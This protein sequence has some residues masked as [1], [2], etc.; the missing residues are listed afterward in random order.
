MNF[1][2]KICQ[3][4]KRTEAAPLPEAPARLE[5]VALRDATMR[6][7]FNT[8]TSELFTN[9]PVGPGDVVADIGCGDGGNARFCAS[10]GARLILADINPDSVAKAAASVAAEP[11]CAG[12]ES[13]ATDSDPLPIA[14]NSVS[15]VVCTEVIEH[16]DE[17]ARLMAE[18][19][20]I[21]QP[22]ARYLIA[23][24]D[25]GSEAV[26]KRLAPPS[27]FEKPNHIRV[28]QHD[29]FA[30]Y[31]ENAGL[32]IE[33]RHSHGFYWSIWWNLFWACDVTLEQP[34]HPLLDS[35]T[36]TWRLLLEQPYGAAIKNALDDL[37]P[38]SQVIIARKP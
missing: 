17:P 4:L 37:R 21:G 23:C 30:R 31:V 3:K 6:G 1:I 7:W 12:V 26:Q 34:A 24:P 27:Y 9:F 11:N 2:T 13:H 33:S 5:D 18:L 19:A 29:E 35:W 15:R 8:E 14:S 10:R 20:R 36:Q 32:I 28:I 25:P 38:M 22:G 16:V